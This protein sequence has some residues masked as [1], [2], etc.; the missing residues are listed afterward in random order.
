[1]NRKI[2]LS[3]GA[4]LIVGMCLYPPWKYEEKRLTTTPGR[5]WGESSDVQS[6][7]TSKLAGYSLVTR[8]PRIETTKSSYIGSSA[9]YVASDPTIAVGRLVMQIALVLLAMFTVAMWDDVRLKARG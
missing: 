5:L 2:A 8:V 1:M 9:R 4:I 7:T 3:V 6:V